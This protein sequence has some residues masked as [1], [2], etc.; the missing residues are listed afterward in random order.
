MNTTDCIRYS[1]GMANMICTSY[2]GD[3]SD[4]DLMVRAV[5]GCNHIKW[6]LGHLLNSQ[7]RMINAVTPGKL[8][9][10]P[11]G[12]GDK[13][14]KETAASDNAADFPSKD[15]LMTLYGKQHDALAAAVDELTEEVMNQ[16]APERL[17]QIAKTAAEVY[18]FQPTHW[19]MHAGQW[20]ILR[21]KLGRPPLF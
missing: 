17:A 12:F 11:A 19:V 20:A 13:F 4:E 5:E 7:N 9:E 10:L 16:P 18:A 21:R 3:L 8:P 14:T 6:Q 1:L 15:E 2:L